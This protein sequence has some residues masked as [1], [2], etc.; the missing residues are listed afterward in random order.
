MVGLLA[1]LHLISKII[2]VNIGVLKAL[3][4]ET[5]ED[6]LFLAAIS[7]SVI[8]FIA[9]RLFLGLFGMDA[10]EIYWWFAIGLT[11]S[12]LRA[13]KTIQNRQN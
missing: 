2:K 1:F 10:Y 13:S 8:G 3:N 5:S 11:I 9:A 12:V 7:K 4:K 6:A